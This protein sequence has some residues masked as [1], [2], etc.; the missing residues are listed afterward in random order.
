MKHPGRE[1]EAE[2]SQ[3][4][5]TRAPQNLDYFRDLQGVANRI[6]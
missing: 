1:F 2:L 5:R 3:I 6:S 4:F